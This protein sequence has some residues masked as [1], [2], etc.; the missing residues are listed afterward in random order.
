M[1]VPLFISEPAAALL[2]T[3][4]RGEVNQKVVG[5]LSEGVRLPFLVPK[6]RLW[7]KTVF[8]SQPSSENA[9]LNFIPGIT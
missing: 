7:S 1:F 4:T 2:V 5:S 3:S 9:D 8:C 6:P